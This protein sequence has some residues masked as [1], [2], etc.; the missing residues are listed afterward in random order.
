MS[1]R[2]SVY[3][4]ATVMVTLFVFLLPGL[5]EEAS[6]TPIAKNASILIEFQVFT[7]NN[8]TV[9]T[10]TTVTWLN[11]DRDFHKI[12][13]DKFESENLIRGDTFSYTFDKA[14]TYEYMDALNPSV[15]GK[16]IVT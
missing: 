11:A 5:A 3:I 8:L 12:K 7:P 10:G 2:G 14:G 15:K 6:S 16:I 4:M 13:G 1:E 9:E